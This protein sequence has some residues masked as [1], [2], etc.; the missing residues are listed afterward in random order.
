MMR[1]VEI[2][3]QN[4][5]RELHHGLIIAVCILLAGMLN[6]GEKGCHELPIVFRALIISWNTQY[7]L[8]NLMGSLSFRSQILRY[9]GSPQPDLGGHGHG[10]HSEVRVVSPQSTV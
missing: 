6:V 3:L 10:V 4:I 5:G 1:S 9:I 2:H 7:G 8:F